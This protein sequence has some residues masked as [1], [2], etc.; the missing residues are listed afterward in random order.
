ME[1]LE[2]RPALLVGL[3]SGD[4]GDVH[5][6]RAIDLVIVNLG[7]D[8]LLGHAH[9]EVAMI[10][11]GLW[12]DSAEVTN[13]RDGNGDEAIE[14]LPHAVSAKRHLGTNGHART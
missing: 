3:G 10:V 14:E 7:E 2:K 9:R 12:T 5:A 13:T 1:G 8:Q 6:T 4:D 11:E